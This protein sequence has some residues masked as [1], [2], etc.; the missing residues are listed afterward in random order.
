MTT[1]RKAL[2]II[3]GIFAT[4]LA[5]VAPLPPS[6]WAGENFILPDGERRGEPID[7][8]RTPHLIE[9]I[10]ALG[11]DSPDNEVAVMKSAQ[12]AFTTA[13]Q[14][15][16]G[17]S[18]DRD[19]CDMM[20]VQPTDSALSDFNSQKLG[21]AI[22]FSREA[23]TKVKPTWGKKVR[24]Q[25][26]RSGTGSTTYEKKYAGGALF[27]A[28][29]SSTA[30]LRSKTIKKAFCDEIDEYPDDL[31]D[32]GDP[33]EMVEARQTSFLRAGTWKRGYF[34]TPTIKGASK[35]EKKFEAGDQRRWHV[36]CPHCGER[37]VFE[38]GKSFV[39]KNA[40]PYEAHYIAP[41]CGVE[42]P[43]WQKYDVY[44]SGIWIP[45]APGAGKPRSY[46]F[47]A[48]SSPFVPWDEIARKFIEA[49]GD[50][51]KLKTFW[52]LVLG[53]PFEVKGDAPDHERLRERVEPHLLRGHVPPRG[54]ILT[55]FADVQMRGIWLEV[56][57]TAPNRETWNVEA[58]Y[59]DGDTSDPHGAVF[60]QLK[61]ETIDREFPDAFGRMR[62]L[63]ALGIDSGFRAHVVYA[64]VRNSQRAHA[65]TGRDLIL[66]TKGLKG[67]GRPA[68]GQPVLVDID[69]G[70]KKI[71]QG[72]KVWGIGTWPLKVSVYGDLRVELPKPPAPPTAPDGFC[73]FGS[74]CDEVY[75]KQLT[76]EQL[77][78]I[79]HRGRVTSRRWVALR[80]NHFHDCRVGNLALAE[81]LGLSSTTPDQ[82]VALARARGLPAELSEASLFTPRSAAKVVDAKDA[83]AAIAARKQSERAPDAQVERSFL[84]GYTVS[85]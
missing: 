29:A 6:A 85:I 36:K 60:A 7:L 8:A 79:T 49:R 16:I 66:A 43:G 77:E 59:I 75:F 15:V 61:K 46:H 5:P 41:C 82:W 48:L 45:T 23:A 26:S 72:A 56:L 2:P 50:Q 35:I 17:H 22:E 63:D 44:L 84:D 32:Q 37:F 25:T 58:L 12:S 62:K 67:W 83:D 47:D 28:L 80:E 1:V 52:N 51:A 81:Y 78:N 3:A 54:L 55:A 11:P 68:L 42:I 10:D 71:P 53:L 13:L 21:R 76:A 70:G 38:W 14:I 64:W 40:Y 19:P 4:M 9:P 65:E 69:L 30:D 34:S 20:A 18:I 31:N 57:A 39:Y 74:W 73:H 27:M 33:L 24:P